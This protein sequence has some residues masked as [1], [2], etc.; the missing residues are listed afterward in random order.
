VIA[1]IL[2][3]HVSSVGVITRAVLVDDCAEGLRNEGRSRTHGTLR[4][5]LSRILWCNGSVLRQDSHVLLQHGAWLL[6]RQMNA[7]P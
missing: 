4:L 6:S 5:P 3:A 7:R 2:W 1:T